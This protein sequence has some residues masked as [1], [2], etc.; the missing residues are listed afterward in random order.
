MV[1]PSATIRCVD[2]SRV[3]SNQVRDALHCIALLA[4]TGPVDFVHTCAAADAAH[5]GCHA[6]PPL[7]RW[8]MEC[9]CAQGVDDLHLNDLTGISASSWQT[10]RRGASQN[11][12]PLSPACRRS[13]LRLRTLR[14]Y[15]LNRRTHR[16]LA[17]IFWAPKR[18]RQ[19]QN[20]RCIP[21]N[22]RC[23]VPSKDADFMV[24]DNRRETT[25]NAVSRA[26]R[27]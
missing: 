7:A 1:L 23:Q 18:W 5:R 17:G 22:Q 20:K 11:L 19:S 26:T 15:A 2:R 9:P 21:V 12:F 10:W 27:W 16:Y 13:R 3:T 6:A 25:R 8:T 14:L 4:M 24:K